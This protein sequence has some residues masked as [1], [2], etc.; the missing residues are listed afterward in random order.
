[1]MDKMSELVAYGVFVEVL[2]ENNSF[3]DIKENELSRGNI[4]FFC[5]HSGRKNIEKALNLLADERFNELCFL[6][7]RKNYETLQKMY[8]DKVDSHKES[9]NKLKELYENKK[10]ETVSFIEKSLFPTWLGT[11]DGL[12]Q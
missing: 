7:I 9:F 2:S 5:E 4:A 12:L 6:I 1:M 3:S 11:V 10:L 8:D